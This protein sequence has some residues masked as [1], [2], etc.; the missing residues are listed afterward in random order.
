V[1]ADRQGRGVYYVEKLG[2]QENALQNIF[3]YGKEEDTEDVVIASNGYQY[4]DEQTGDRFLVLKDGTRYDGQPG[5]ADYN[6]LEFETYALRIRSKVI[7]KT[8]STVK[9]MPTRQLLQT[10]TP[11]AQAEWHW[12]LSKPISVPILTLLALSFTYISV[13][14]SQF[15]RMVVAFGVYFL[16]S[17]V[18]GYGNA[19]IKKGKV[20]P[21]IGLWW[22][23][24]LFA[25]IAI[26]MFLRRSQNKPLMFSWRPW[27]RSR[28]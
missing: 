2:D 10:K 23:H 22:V 3:I 16:Y 7:T 26:Y 14:R 12:R 28:A 5:T 27:R 18:L 25:V 20:D 1:F 13:R 4:I 19:L 8:I 6:I 24:T 9:A 11:R 15:L 21:E 17:N